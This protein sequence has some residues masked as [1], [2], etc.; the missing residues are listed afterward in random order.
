MESLTSVQMASVTSYW[1]RIEDA[2]KKGEGLLL[3]G[4][5]GVGK[6]WAMAALTRQYAQK[7]A[8]VRVPSYE[9]VTA[10]DMFDNLGDFGE[11]IDHYRGQLWTSTYARVRWLVINDLG[12]EHRGGKLSEVMAHRLGRVL[13]IRSERMLVTHVTTNLSGA[14]M[15]EIYGASVMSL[16]AEMMTLCVIKGRDRRG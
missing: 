12:K 13:R 16:M 4:P 8:D 1:E 3:S 2:I 9:F 10:P 15:K 6:T 14:D 7:T 5:P 11:K